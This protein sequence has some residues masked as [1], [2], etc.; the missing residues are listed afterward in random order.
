[1]QIKKK[2]LKNNIRNLENQDESMRGLA[3]TTTSSIVL[4]KY[5]QK[6]QRGGGIK[7]E[8]QYGST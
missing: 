4:G 6:A 5:A 1:M 8:N 3:G 2:E 7:V